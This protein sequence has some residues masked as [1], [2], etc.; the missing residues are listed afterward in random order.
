MATKL[1][2]IWDFN[3]IKVALVDAFLKLRPRT[4]I[5]NPVMFT[6]YVGS[7]ITTILFLQSLLGKGEAP[8]FFYFSSDIMPL[9]YPPIC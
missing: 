4:Q 2:S 6:V 5:K 1:H 3:I 8:T 9:V 7:I